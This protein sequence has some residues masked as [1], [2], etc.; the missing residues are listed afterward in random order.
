MQRSSLVYTIAS[1]NSIRLAMRSSSLSKPYAVL[2]VHARA[3]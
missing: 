1:Q 3:I 2:F